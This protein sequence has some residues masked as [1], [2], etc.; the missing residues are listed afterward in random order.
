MA[1]AEIQAACQFPETHY[2]GKRIG[3]PLG[4]GLNCQVSAAWQ[5]ENEL[6]I[7]CHVIDMHLAQLRIAV[8]FKDNTV[9]IHT[10]KHAEFILQEYAG[11]ASGEAKA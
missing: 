11:F 5:R 1:G 6:M 7:Y 4:R 10:A 9:T 2:N 3:A 8:S